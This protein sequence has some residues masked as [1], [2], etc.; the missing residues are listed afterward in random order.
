MSSASMCES[1][2][3]GQTNMPFVRINAALGK[4]GCRRRVRSNELLEGVVAGSRLCVV[5]ARFKLRRDD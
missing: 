2:Q 4:D 1:E 5:F 3:T